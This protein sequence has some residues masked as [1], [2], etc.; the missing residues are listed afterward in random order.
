MP[1]SDWHC[2]FFTAVA[3]LDRGTIAW[4]TKRITTTISE[5]K[6]R[7]PGL[8]LTVN[9][10]DK[11]FCRS[12]NLVGKA[13]VYDSGNW[14]HWRNILWQHCE[15]SLETKE[16]PISDSLEL[17]ARS[18]GRPTWRGNNGPYTK[19]A[20]YGDRDLNYQQKHYT[21]ILWIVSKL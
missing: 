18:W 21:A 10:S 8:S 11:I 17:L 19:V 4:E 2:T 6:L 13:V 5:C 9:Y 20:L 15:T 12:P 1:S 16:G 3:L 7:Q 14:I